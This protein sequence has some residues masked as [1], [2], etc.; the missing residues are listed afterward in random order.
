VTKINYN[1]TFEMNRICA[2]S[3]VDRHIQK[4]PKHII[5]E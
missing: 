4:V 1:S 2:F 3:K 5:T